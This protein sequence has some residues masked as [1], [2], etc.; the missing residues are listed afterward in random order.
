MSAS[1][2]N[3]SKSTKRNASRWLMRYVRNV[4]TWIGLSIGVALTSGLL[5]ILQAGLLAN[6]IQRAYIENQSRHELLTLIFSLLA[7]MLIRAGLLWLREVISFNAGAKV[8]A[9]VRE[10]LQ[11]G[12]RQSVN[13]TFKVWRVWAHNFS[14]FCKV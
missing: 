11:W 7:I 12:R 2:S 5:L 3:I 13:A 6:I 8:R 10:E 14:M 4:R 9:T 1:N